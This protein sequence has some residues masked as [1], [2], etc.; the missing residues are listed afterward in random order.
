MCLSLKTMNLHKPDSCGQVSQPQTSQQ[1]NIA[2]CKAFIKNMPCYI[3]CSYA[4][5]NSQLTVSGALWNFVLLSLTP[6]HQLWHMRT[7]QQQENPPPHTTCDFR[8]FFLYSSHRQ[9]N[10]WRC[11]VPFCVYIYFAAMLAVVL[12]L[13]I[14]YINLSAT[15]MSTDCYVLRVCLWV[16]TYIYAIMWRKG[17]LVHLPCI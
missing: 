16:F 10:I 3:P 15:Y 5:L 8:H 2:Y 12:S 1:I 4:S 7:R 11:F 13:W 14:F 6:H 17:T 9:H